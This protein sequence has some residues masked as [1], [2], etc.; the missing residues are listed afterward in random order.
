MHSAAVTTAL[1]SLLAA[2]SAAAA[3]PT[4][5]PPQ[6]KESA[7]Q[8][9]A[10]VAAG[11][12]RQ[13]AARA[14]PAVK[15]P[16]SCVVCDALSLGCIA[17]CALGGPLDPACDLCAGGALGIV[18]QCLTVSLGLPLFVSFCWGFG[19]TFGLRGSPSCQMHFVD[20]CQVPWLMSGVSSALHP[21]RWTWSGGCQWVLG[22]VC[23]CREREMENRITTLKI[24]LSSHWSP[25][26][27]IQV[28]PLVGIRP[29]FW[30]RSSQ[31]SV[32][33]SVT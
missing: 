7:D 1:L 15:V 26:G 13:L 17:A 11:H 24:A 20:V 2:L 33:V 12:A 27:R 19:V 29:P 30:I 4:D 6:V 25:A 32:H 28:T 16:P 21:T 18:A 5:N 14:V 3:A 23:R 9:N 31:L 22:L 10:L 8:A